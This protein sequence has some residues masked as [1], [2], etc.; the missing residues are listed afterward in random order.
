MEQQ[1]IW[2]S[3]HLQATPLIRPFKVPAHPTELGLMR[4]YMPTVHKEY[5]AFKAHKEYKELPVRREHKV[6]R[7]LLVRR[8]LKAL[9]RRE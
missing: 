3:Q 1:I 6:Y 9:G 7:A 8:E 2:T 4:L 5:K